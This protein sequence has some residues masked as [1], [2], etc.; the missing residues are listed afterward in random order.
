[1]NKWM[2]DNFIYTRFK[3]AYFVKK[4]RQNPGHATAR[5]VTRAVLY[6]LI[7][8]ANVKTKEFTSRKSFGR[9]GSQT[10]F[11]GGEKRRLPEI[12]LRPQAN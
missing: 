1:M 4:P 6:P 9:S 12:S 3:K 5:G 10:L 8:L 11:S 7:S 2:N